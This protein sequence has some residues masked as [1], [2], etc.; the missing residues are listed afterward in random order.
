MKKLN[1]T[2]CLL[3]SACF[4]LGCSSGSGDR[5]EEN[6]SY[7]DYVQNVRFVQMLTG[8][9]SPNE[10]TVYD[11][12]GTDLGF[13]IYNSQ[14][15]TMY[16]AFGDTFSKPTQQG[17]WRSNVMAV[18]KDADF[19]DGIEIDS[20][21]AGGSGIARAMIDGHHIDNYEMTKIPTGGIEIGGVMYLFYMSVRH[22]GEAGLWDVNYNG[23]VKSGDEGKTWERV[24]DLTWVES[25]TENAENIKTLAEENA[26]MTEKGGTV[27]LSGRVAPAFGQIFPIDG[28]DGYVYL[29]GIPGGR[30]GGAKLARVK[31]ELF[32]QFDSYEYYLGPDESGEPRFVSGER[33]LKLMNAADSAYVL[34]APCSELSGMYNPYLGKWMAVYLNYPNIVFRTADAPYGPFSAPEI[35]ITATEYPT[36]YGGHVHEKYTKEN[37]RVFGFIMSQW[38]PIYNSMV[39]EVTLK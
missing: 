32:E 34:D 33:G 30:T 1:F 14:N 8:K 3:L 13:P 22:W 20:F 10:T 7:S 5:K 9:D 6:L 21:I 27:D 26:D 17:N 19:S 37:G 18:S 2:L 36:L 24:Y 11:V 35:L 39:I 28:K 16:L 12:G 15:D 38:M 4:V 25:A 31:T 23:V 29:Y